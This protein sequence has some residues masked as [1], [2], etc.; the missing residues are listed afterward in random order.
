MYRNMEKN[1]NIPK[2]STIKTH[3]TRVVHTRPQM[4]D[5]NSYLEMLG[6]SE[7]EKTQL[8]NQLN[9]WD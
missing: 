1:K 2:K 3:N 5:V 8:R 7:F 6:K 4:R 9:L